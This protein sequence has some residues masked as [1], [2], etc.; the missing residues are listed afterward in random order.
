M[1]PQEFTAAREASGLGRRDFGRMIGLNGDGR[2]I[3]IT[4]QR[5]EAGARDISPTVGRLVRMLLWF[6]E[7]YGYFP[8]PGADRPG[9]FMTTEGADD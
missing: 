8:D 1:T 6:H 5:Y 3:W 7:E 9:R 4:I 2:N